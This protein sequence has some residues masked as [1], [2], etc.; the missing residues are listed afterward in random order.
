MI[1]WLVTRADKTTVSAFAR[2]AWRTVGAICERVVAEQLDSTRFEGLVNIG[3]DEISWRKHHRYL[4]LVSDHA[5]SK[6][7]WGAPG[8]NAATLDGFFH[9]IGAENTAA[10]EAVSMDMGPAFAKSV[11]ANAPAAVICFDP[12]HVIQLATNALE[13]F[14]RS[15]WQRTRELPDQD[16]AKKFKGTRWV[17][18]KNPQDLTE[19]QQVTLAGLEHT[20]GL[21]WDA[22]QLKESLR[23]V[24]AGDLNPEDVMEMITT[25]CGLAAASGIKEFT[26][27]AATIRSHIQGIY[28]AVTRKLSNGRHEGLNNKIRTMTRRSYGFHTPEAALA[29]IM[30]ACG[31]VRIK[32]PY[33][34]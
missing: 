10:I 5:T 23:E 31:P 17:L 3:V 20:G 24:F 19:K 25:W 16:I 27:A 9:E 28:A 15:I 8:K 2:I 12:F 4:T 1:A 7:V 18:L 30:L 14:R 26:R 21:L 34:R 32:L 33:Q 6:I 29:L 13:A 11:K 22:Y